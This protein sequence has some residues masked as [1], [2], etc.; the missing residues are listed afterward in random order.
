M[1]NGVIVSLCHRQGMAVLGLSQME[2]CGVACFARS[3]PWERFAHGHIRKPGGYGVPDP[4]VHASAGACSP[5]MP[6]ALHATG[7]SC[8][9]SFGRLRRKGIEAVPVLQSRFVWLR[10]QVQNRHA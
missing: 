5:A 6:Y 9:P 4:G 10:E 2:C 8:R 1:V 3:F 7:M